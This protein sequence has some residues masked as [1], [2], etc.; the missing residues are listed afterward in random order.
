MQS[1]FKSLIVV[2]SVANAVCLAACI[3]TALGYFAIYDLGL[4]A[5]CVRGGAVITAVVLVSVM[6]LDFFGKKLRKAK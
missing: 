5:E 3:A 1:R 6:A 4:S 2:A